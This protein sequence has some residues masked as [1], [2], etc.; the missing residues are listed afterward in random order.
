M[1]Y[2][3]GYLAVK[4]RSSNDVL[5]ALSLIRTGESE[6][7]P[8]SDFNLLEINDWS[9]IVST[10]SDFCLAIEK[11]TLDLA[12]FPE[13]VICFV[14]EHVMYC[15]SSYWRSGQRKWFV[16]HES[17]KGERHLNE[18]GTFPD[19]YTAIKTRLSVEQDKQDAEYIIYK[20]NK[21]SWLARLLS[22]SP[23]ATEF[24]GADYFFS[25][26]VETAEFYTGYSYDK[27][28]PGNP[29]YEILIPA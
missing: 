8:E 28:P 20:K 10:D 13:A 14:E 6:E 24:H 19:E 15:S 27:E 25:I 1:G 22:N 2:C 29:P 21:K 12:Q 3:G 18:Q 26:P 9:I 17:E 4:G 23:K 16:E 7:L 11:Q 5:K